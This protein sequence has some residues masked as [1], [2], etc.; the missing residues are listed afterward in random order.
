MTIPNVR[1]VR[2]RQCSGLQLLSWGWL[3]VMGIGMAASAAS[4][5]ELH[6]HRGA[7]G[8][9]PE[10]TLASF[11]EAIRQ[12]VDC[13]ETDVGLLR[14][15]HV[16]IHHDRFVSPVLARSGGVW[17]DAPVLLRSLSATE[18]K[19]YD[20]GRIKPGT[21]YA[22]KFAS[23]RPIDGA[24]IPLLAELLAMPEL[25]AHPNVCLN[26]EIKTSP[27]A[28]DDTFA[29]ERVS[30]ALVRVL[31]GFK[32]RARTRVQSFDWRNLRT[33]AKLAPDLAL[34]FLT[35]E[36]RWQDNVQRGKP[37][38]SPWLGGIDI[39][40]FDGS[41]PRAVAHLGG[42]FWAPYYRDLATDDV[43]AAH[44]LGLKVI[45]WT[46]NEEADIRAMLDMGVDGIITDY[47]DR[48]RSILDAWHK[49]TVKPASGN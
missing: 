18:L 26:I 29:P 3:I 7:R 13:I 12:G 21:R 28:P 40:D 4:A 41:V 36:R 17:I 20:V 1:G 45:V 33:V 24:R 16:V 48:G 8:L 9:L 19:R 22:A 15:G 46:V 49:G 30:Q 42:R 23:Q 47:P 38:A 43:K 32:F 5:V 2:W 31:D 44:S 14:D 11:R 34:S 27:E 35:A 25:A 10:N 6:G 39:D 37:G